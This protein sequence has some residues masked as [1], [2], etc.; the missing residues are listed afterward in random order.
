MNCKE[1]TDFLMEYMDGELPGEQRSAFEQHIAKCPPCGEYL[2]SYEATVRM[3]RELGCETRDPD[4]EV[5]PEVPEQ[6]IQAIL[7]TL[8]ARKKN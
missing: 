4:A 2:S 8:A 1:F 5:P 6:L 7:A 3:G